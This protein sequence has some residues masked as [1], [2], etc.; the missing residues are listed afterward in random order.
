MI[1]QDKNSSQSNNS[2]IIKNKELNIWEALTPVIAL[3]GML[4]YNIYVFGDD[5]LSGSNQFILLMGASI[6]AIVGFLNKISYQQMLEEVAENVKSTT[7]ALLILLMV[8]ALAGTWM[9]SGVIPTMIYYGLQILNPKIFLAAC[10]VICAIISIATGSSWTTSA[11]VGI[12]LVGIGETLGVSMGMTAGAV[13]SGAYF[14]DKMSP[15]SDTTNLAPAMAGGELFDHI[16][17]MSFTTIPTISITLI[18]F[19]VIGLNLDINGTPQ[20][21][22]KL[23]AINDA[24]NISPWLFLV[25]ISV[26]LMII[27]KTPPLIALLL[28]ALFGGIAAII[29]QPNI[30][31]DIAGTDT[32]TF[33]SSYKGVINAMT[34]DTAVET[35][36]IELNNL[37]T[38]GGMAG[39]LGT[40]W[41]IICAMVFGGV[42]DAIGALSRITNALLNMATTTFGLFAS[43]VASCL[44]LNV[45]ASDQY[46]ALVVPGKMFKKAYEDK[47]L[48][49][50]NL[51]RTLEDSGTVTSVLVPWNTC[52]AYHSKVLFGYAGATAYIPYAF[53]SILSPIMTLLFAGFSIKIKQLKGDFN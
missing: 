12:A 40:I 18:L 47:G 35:T 52:G 43:T 33:K 23:D 36:S 6:A 42:M 31:M 2:T 8:G 51:S 25:P 19:I 11:T 48:A 32:L 50:E 5:A 22:D 45:T 38:S 53:F 28:G 37:F 34:V 16:K 39:M 30:I 17:Y 26:I 41:L 21:Q 27:K 13:L 9:V 15:L 46:L 14:G 1:G 29:A 3:V 24:F 44:A 49:P 4:A 20:I 7:G 10:V